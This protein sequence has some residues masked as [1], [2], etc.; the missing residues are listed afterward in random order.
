L[1]AMSLQCHARIVSGVTIVAIHGHPPALV[2]GEAGAP[3]AGLELSLEDAV[4]FD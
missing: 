4:L 3:P 2:I 1:A